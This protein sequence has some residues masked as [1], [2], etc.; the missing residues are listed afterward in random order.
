MAIIANVATFPG[1]RAISARAIKSIASQVDR[2]NIVLNEYV[3]VPGELKSVPKANFVFPP[4]DLKDVGKFYPSVEPDD[5]VFL[6]DDDILYPSDYVERMM[7]FREQIQDVHPI[8]GLHSIIYSDYYEGKHGAGRLVDVFTKALDRPRLV[9]QVGT[10][11]VYCKGYQ[12]PEFRFMEGSEKFVD[13]RF[14]RH[15]FNKGYPNISVAREADWMKQLEI[16]GSIYESF[17]MSK[18][19]NVIREVQEIGGFKKLDPNMWRLIEEHVVAG[20]T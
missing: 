1:R 9:N 7:S 12:M 4:R 11:T 2:V 6:I 18:P 14:A 17:T 8:L 20:S 15:S 13:V 5:D 10:G 3:Y 16:E 19:L